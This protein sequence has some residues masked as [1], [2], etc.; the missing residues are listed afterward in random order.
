MSQSVKEILEEINTCIDKA[1]FV[2]I[3]IGE[4]FQNWKMQEADEE[5]RKGELLG[6]YHRLERMVNGKPYF[7]V[8]QNQGELIFDSEL[9]DFFIAAPF[10]GEGREQSSQEQ[11]NA[12]LNWL[13]ATLNH[14]LCILE[15]GVGFSAPQIIRWPFEKTALYNFKSTLIRINEKFPQLPQEI[16]ERGISFSGNAVKLLLQAETLEN[17]EI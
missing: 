7:V 2:L 10:A 12:Y 13:T 8:T 5:V 17:A 3:G 6:A 14:K 16:A 9:L 15:L 1:E 11:W 4:E